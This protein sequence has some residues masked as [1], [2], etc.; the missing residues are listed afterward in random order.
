M[1]TQPS[2]SA[3]LRQEV[4]T[5]VLAAI[6]AAEISKSKLADL[7]GIPYSSLNR[8]LI[9]RAEFSFE[10]LFLIADATGRMPSDFTPRAFAAT[11]YVTERVA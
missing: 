3:E 6:G 4:A 8:K 5:L 11:Q 1:A 10:E 9:G 2:R 7:T